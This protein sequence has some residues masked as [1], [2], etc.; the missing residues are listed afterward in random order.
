MQALLPEDTLVMPS[1]GR[2]FR[3][4]GTRVAQLQ[5]HHQ[6]RLSELLAACCT[7]PCSALDALPVLFKRPLNS[8][9]MA[10]AMGE[11]IA[12]L[13]ALWHAGQVQRQLDPMDGVYRFSASPAQRASVGAT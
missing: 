6:E 3:G 11:A 2:P 7:R 5:T 1:H 8:Q 12:H 9:Q 13:H 4:V 10:F